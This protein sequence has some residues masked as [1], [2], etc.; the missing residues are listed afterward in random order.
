MVGLQT[1][2][3]TPCALIAGR[4]A[5]LYAGAD[6]LDD[7]IC[8]NRPGGIVCNAIEEFSAPGLTRSGHW[9]FAEIKIDADL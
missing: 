6:K 9:P 4:L 7:L 2:F 3:T 5:P 8:G 1:P